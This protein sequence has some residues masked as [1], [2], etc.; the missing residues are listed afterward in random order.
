MGQELYSFHMRALTMPACA[1]STFHSFE[2]SVRNV[3]N[4]GIRPQN[5]AAKKSGW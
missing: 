2:Y 4:V 5:A 1:S 3:S